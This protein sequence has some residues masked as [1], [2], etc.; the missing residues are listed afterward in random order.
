M[1]SVRD[2]V[3]YLCENY[4][5]KNELSKARVTKMVYLADWRSCIIW[6]RQIT[7]IVWEYNYYGPY[8]EDVLNIART[9]PAFE[10]ET[11]RNVRGGLKEIIRLI[12]PV[13]YKT[14]NAEDTAILDFV[15]QTTAS[16]FWDDFIHL[17][18]STYPIITQPKFSKLDL[19]SLAREYR[20]QRA[21]AAS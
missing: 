6:E 4:P 16:K 9:D 3:A 10:I 17:V 15:I 2:V 5:H 1:A 14:L 11:T 20:E 18:Y 13:E 19:V 12:A 21:V 8:V 7:E